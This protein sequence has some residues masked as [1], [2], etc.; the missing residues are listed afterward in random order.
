MS[1]SKILFPKDFKWGV[2]TSAYQIEGAWNKDGKGKSIWDSFCHEQGKII[3]GTTGDIACNH[4]EKFPQDIATMREL[5]IRNYRCSISWPRVMPEGKNK[6]NPAGL[7]YYDRLIDELCESNIDPFVT[8]YHWDLPQVL[9][10][11][12][13]WNN[14]D[15]SKYFADYAALM[16]KKL[17]DRVKFWAT[18][19]EPWVI[20]NLGHKTGE[21]APGLKDQKLTLQVIH[22]L[23]LAHGMAVQAIRAC[24]PKSEVGIVQILFPTHP[25]SDSQAD[26]KVAEFTWQRESAWFLDPLFKAS[27]PA[28]IWESYGDMVPQ[29]EAGDMALISQKLDFLGVNFYF[30]NVMSAENGRL[31]KIPG[32]D[33]TDMGW[34]VHAPGLRHLLLRLS[35]EYKLPPLYITENGA[36]YQDVLTADG[37]VHDQNRLEYVRDH[38]LEAHA[39][40]QEGVDLRGYFLWSLLDNFEWAYG[41]SKRFGIIYVDYQSLERYPKDSALWYAKVIKR[42]GLDSS[43]ENAAQLAYLHH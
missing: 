5:G 12:G 39:A 19:N 21:M 30:R 15:V 38:L 35:N 29:V 40:I 24:E 2:A 34:E 33:Y 26:Q 27:Y 13:G 1:T 6:I 7:D 28:E 16:A 8:L 11:M 18:L 42:N 4:Y 25:A 22:N 20:A 37:R 41:L 43:L 36:A 32:A 10:D 31:E 9:Q 23:M 14:R 17:G 3:D